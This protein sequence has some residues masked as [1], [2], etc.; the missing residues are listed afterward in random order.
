MTG[1]YSIAEVIDDSNK[2]PEKTIFCLLIRDESD[3][4]DDGQR[5]SLIKVGE[6]V[7]RNGGK[8]FTNLSDV[9]D[10]LNGKPSFISTINLRNSQKFNI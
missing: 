6:M 7:E 2:R 3:L 5:K 9:A 8:F 1:V 4:F 10:Y